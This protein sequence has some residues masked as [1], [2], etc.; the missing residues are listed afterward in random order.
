[1]KSIFIFVVFVAVAVVLAT[2]QTEEMEMEEVDIVET[3][4]TIEVELEFKNINVV[5]YDLDLV[6]MDEDSNDV[7][8]NEISGDISEIDLYTIEEDDGMPTY[9]VNNDNIGKMYKITYVE[10]IVEGDLSGEPTQ[11]KDILAMEEISQN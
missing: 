5:E 4:A 7:W 3:P 11:I 1:M 9:I 2:A 8:F 10:R 6:F